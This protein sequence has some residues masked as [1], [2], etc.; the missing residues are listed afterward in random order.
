MLFP[1]RFP[2]RHA[3]A[4]QAGDL[5]SATRRAPSSRARR[6]AAIAV[7]LCASLGLLGCSPFEAYSVWFAVQGP[8]SPPSGGA[9]ACPQGEPILSEIV[10]RDMVM[11]WSST[12]CALLSLREN[13]G[14]GV[15]EGP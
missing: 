7:G 10:D 9:G 14:S 12:V 1:L 15:V 13:V 3:V 8:E 6:A 4:G 2:R 5:R 11:R